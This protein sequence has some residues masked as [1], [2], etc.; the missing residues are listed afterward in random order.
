[1]DL[2]IDLN[3]CRG[4]SLL[5]SGARA[6]LVDPK[7]IPQTLDLVEVRKEGLPGKY[8]VPGIPC[9]L[10]LQKQKRGGSKKVKAG[11]PVLVRE[12]HAI[13]GVAVQGFFACQFELVAFV[14][15]AVH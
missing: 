9:A 13:H 15:V 14:R 4:E 10:P 12:F 2:R 11:I 3:F 1:M 8:L 5:D 6:A 7:W